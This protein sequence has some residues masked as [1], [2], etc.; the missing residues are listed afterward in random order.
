MN[1][2]IFLTKLSP[3][4]LFQLIFPI[5]KFVVR[6]DSMLPTLRPGDMIL[7]NKWAPVSRGNVVVAKRGHRLLLKRVERVR[8]GG[9]YLI[10]D[11]PEH[12]QDSRQ[13]GWIPR[14]DVLG[15]VFFVRRLGEGE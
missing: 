10:G 15:V 9:V 8:V 1:W 3:L 13:L 6:E 7:T 12:S 14:R 4:S 5:R 11:N 2:P